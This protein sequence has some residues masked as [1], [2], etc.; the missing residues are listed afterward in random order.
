MVGPA[1]NEITII[2]QLEERRRIIISSI[3]LSSAQLLPFYPPPN[4]YLFILRP[5]F[6]FL[7][8]AQLLS[9][10][11]LPNF[12][13]FIFRPTFMKK[14]KTWT[15]LYSHG[16]TPQ[17]TKPCKIEIIVK[18]VE[19]HLTN[20]TKTLFSSDK[21]F[22]SSDKF[23]PSL[24]TSCPPLITFAQEVLGWRVVLPVTVCCN[25]KVM[26]AQYNNHN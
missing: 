26:N 13:L 15:A 5:T 18:I 1:L 8:S 19:S 9:F 25:V 23:V 21:I 3:F 12:Y 6:I 16:L 24:I 11:P 10:Y 22:S 17:I 14:P 4:F 20:I 2:F 7:S